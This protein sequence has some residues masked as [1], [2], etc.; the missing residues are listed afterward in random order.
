MF[1][2]HVYT[3][4]CFQGEWGGRGAGPTKNCFEYENQILKSYKS[5]KYSRYEYIYVLGP[6]IPTML[7]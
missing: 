2:K 6:F 1:A 7:F 3:E 5:A 4:H